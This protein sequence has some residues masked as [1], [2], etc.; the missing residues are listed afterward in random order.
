MVEAH[1]NNGTYM[2]VCSPEV[3]NKPA[4]LRRGAVN[5]VL[6]AADAAVHGD[7][8]LLIRP[9]CDLLYGEL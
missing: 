9:P 3:E 4:H 1:A 7:C 2:A 8:Q 5:Q 6:E